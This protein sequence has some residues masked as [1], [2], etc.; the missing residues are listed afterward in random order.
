MVL[1]GIRAALK[2]VLGSSSA[3]LVYGATLRIPGEMLL[4]NLNPIKNN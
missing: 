3:K 2:E 1:L 4:E